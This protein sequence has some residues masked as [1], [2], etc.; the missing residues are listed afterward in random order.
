MEVYYREGDEVW[1]GDLTFLRLSESERKLSDFD[2]KHWPEKFTAEMT[3]KPYSSFVTFD[4]AWRKTW[5]RKSVH[6][7]DPYIESIGSSRIVIQDKEGNTYKFYTEKPEWVKTT[8]SVERWAKENKSPEE[9]AEEQQERDDLDMM[10]K[11]FGR[12]ADDVL[13]EG[14]DDSNQG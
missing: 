3:H 14:L 9:L 13:A 11:I 12:V 7:E 10:S 5:P 4:T 8:I 6:L 2:R 1:V